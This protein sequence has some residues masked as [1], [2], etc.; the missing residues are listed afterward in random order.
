M[1]VRLLTMTQ[2]G[3]SLGERRC[4]VL[5]PCVCARLFLR[6]VMRAFCVLSVRWWALSCAEAPFGRR[7]AG[8]VRF[9]FLGHWAC[10]VGSSMGSAKVRSHAVNSS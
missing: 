7:G 4:V 5:R 1:L 9:V 2:R 10:V 6:A 8:R 3:G